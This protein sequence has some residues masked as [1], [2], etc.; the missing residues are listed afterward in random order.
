[1]V[2]ELLKVHVFIRSDLEMTRG[3]ISV[4]ASHATLGLHVEL[5]E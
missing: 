2:E 1:M 4:Q 3:K 5:I